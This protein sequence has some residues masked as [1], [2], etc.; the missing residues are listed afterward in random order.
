MNALSNTYGPTLDTFLDSS[1]SVNLSNCDREPIHRPGAIQPHGLLLV[2]VEPDLHICQIS[3]NAQAIIAIAPEDLLD[4]PLSDFIEA[5]SLAA[6]RGCLEREFE[7]I[8]P[9]PLDFACGEAVSKTRSKT[10]NGIVHRAP[11]GEV[12][13]ELEPF[14]DDDRGDFFYFHR[15]VKQT[16]TALQ[17]SKNLEELGTR[18]VNEIKALTDFDRVMIYRF[19][20]KGD[21]FVIA[22]AKEPELE[23]FLGLHYPATDVPQQARYLYTQNWLRLIPDISYKPS[24]LIHRSATSSSELDPAPNV[25]LDVHPPINLEREAID[26]R[27]VKP[28]IKPK[29]NPKAKPKINPEPNSKLASKTVKTAN[30]QS[31]TDLSFSV[32]RSVS[33][34]H[35]EYM[36]NMGVAATMV[37][38]LLHNGQLWGV[39]ACHHYHPKFI[40]YGLR[41][42]CE[43]LGQLMSAEIVHKEVNDNIDYQLQLKDIQ[44][45]LV[46]RLARGMD[47]FA[48]LVSEADLLLKLTAATGL[49][50][51]SG[52]DRVAIGQTPDETALTALLE[53]LPDQFDRDLLMTDTLASLYPPAAAYAS[54]ASGL[55]AM[56]ISKLQHR[57]I[58]WFRPEVLQTVTWAGKPNNKEE[59]VQANGTTILIPRRS[60]EAW[61]ETVRGTA[62]PWLPCEI[63]GVLELRQA[64]VEI[65]LRQADALTSLNQDLQRMNSELDAFAYLASHDLK[66]P[67]R[68][69]HNYATFL[70]EDYG[71][72]LAGDGAEKLNTLVRLTQRMDL[73]IDSLLRFSRLGRQELQMRPI[74]LNAMLD[75]TVA[76]F[77]MN[78]QWED[79][80]IRINDTLPIV[81][82]DY[83]L[84][85][86][87]FI[88]LIANGLKYNRQANKWV[89]VGYCCEADF[90]DEST[91]THFVTLYVRDNGI[92]IRE[93][94]F[95]SIFRIF[96]RL[97]AQGQYGGGS[98]AGL[99]IV[100]KIVER[101]GG[102]IRVES[103]YGEGT[104][105]LI[106]LPV[107][108]LTPR[109]F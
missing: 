80:D 27:S 46:G 71:K 32:L 37:I 31:P 77:R 83:S 48:A 34:L 85:E 84:V 11:S 79:C 7:H 21:G 65:V 26:D 12:I 88:N 39:I 69:I 59:R 56:A 70:L 87:I 54:A 10:F 19:N 16:L 101:H 108:H 49:V 28:K 81:W 1:E 67:L 40:S 95:D 104:T 57:Y 58:L 61:Q 36:Q 29:I 33:P 68:G 18:I 52:N 13:L 38:S 50:I 5:P 74:H 4:R 20:E 66:E 93:K 89:E 100:R 91:G 63:S 35:V 60:F 86:E 72:I 8:N 103:I 43:F 55:L 14:T 30:E 17:A 78:H 92:G 42:V 51:C 102:T 109:G 45:V 6:I 94:H 90:K 107:H 82:G 9:L 47:F 2:L 25:R 15:Q 62:L 97:H 99:T 44:S 3:D 106:N 24:S 41:T 76:M 73:L 22:E 105:F 64:I 96:K 98:G 23:P 75:E 53:W